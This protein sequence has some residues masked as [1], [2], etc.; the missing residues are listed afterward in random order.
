MNAQMYT[1]SGITEQIG[2][3][4]KSKNALADAL[5]GNANQSVQFLNKN[6]DHSL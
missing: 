4:T 1:G 5:T 3:L 2:E 6:L